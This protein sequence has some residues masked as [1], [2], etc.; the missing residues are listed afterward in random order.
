[1][2]KHSVRVS[3]SAGGG[4][5]GYPRALSNGIPADDVRFRDGSGALQ[6]IATS[7]GQNDAG[8]FE[9]AMRD[10]RYLPYEGAGAIS[11]WRLE[12]PMEFKTFDYGAISDV[13][14][15]MR[16]TARDCGGE[17]SAAATTA[18]RNLLGAVNAQPLLRLFSLRHEFPSEWRRF[19]SSPPSAVN[20][21]TVDLATARFPYF[22]Q[23]RTITVKMAKVI[24]RTKSAALVQMAIAPGQT[25]PDLTQSA[26]TGQGDPGPW[27]VATGS[28]PKLVEDIFV[29]FAYGAN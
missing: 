8:L 17:L 10:E 25:T 20:I 16:Y 7:T 29:I 9:P 14:I 5:N 2:T 28:D 23:S 18:A 24:A 4:A 15:H 1:M 22:A 11:R 6:S 3:S 13:I 21:M 27:T 19:V 26:W 12:L